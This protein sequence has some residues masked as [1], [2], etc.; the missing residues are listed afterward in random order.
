MARRAHTGRVMDV[1]MCRWCKR[2][3][4][5]LETNPPE[6]WYQLPPGWF[7][8]DGYYDEGPSYACSVACAEACTVADDLEKEFADLQHD[9]YG[10]TR[11]NDEH[12]HRTALYEAEKRMKAKHG[13]EWDKKTWPNVATR[14]I[15]R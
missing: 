10:Q 8:Q 11:R 1:D 15:T 13:T 9:A 6:H 12:P 4:P 3:M 14:E 7:Q 2:P 5:P